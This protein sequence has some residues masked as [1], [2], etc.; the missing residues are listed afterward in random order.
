MLLACPSAAAIAPAFWLETQSPLSTEKCNGV[1]TAPVSA[2][3]RFARSSDFKVGVALPG[4]Q[5]CYQGD[6]D[7]ELELLALASFG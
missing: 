4:H 3:S 5:R 6:V 2:P 7:I 1:P